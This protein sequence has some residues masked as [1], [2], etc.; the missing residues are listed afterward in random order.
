[1]FE[2]KGIG[3]WALYGDS[4]TL[5]PTFKRTA[6]NSLIGVLESRDAFDRF[7]AAIADDP[8]LDVIVEREMDYWGRWVKPQTD[9]YNI[10]AYGVGGIMAVGALF[11]ALNIMYAAVSART[12]EI[13]T[14]RAIGFSPTPVVVSVFAE[15]LL[16]S[17]V[18]AAA[19]V[20]AAWAICNGY[21]T[22]TAGFAMVV[23]PAL[24]WVGFG[25]AV[26][27]GSVAALFPAVRAAR[28]PI[29][30]ALQAR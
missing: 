17:V 11:A 9:F 16:L 15:S 13:A 6:Y 14:L 21:Y 25:V 5:M 10:I 24:A 12:I 27:V 26:L 2:S 29:T 4:A 19:G 22:P 3:D 20:A 7:K 1:M 23:S 8:T 18:G 28:L 30:L